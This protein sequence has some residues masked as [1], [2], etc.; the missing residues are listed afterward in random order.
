MDVRKRILIVEDD[1]DIRDSLVELLEDSGY[2]VETA[3]NGQEGLDVLQSS[4]TPDLILL[5]LMMPIKDGFA[6]RSEQLGMPQFA[7]IPVIIMSAD[8]QV[9]EKTA[10]TQCAAYIRKP[11]EIDYFLQTVSS[12]LPAAKF[13]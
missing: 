5:D 12:N 10:Q 4:V 11:L 3:S 9:K 2:A 13:Q 1:L 6:F 7:Q 8:G